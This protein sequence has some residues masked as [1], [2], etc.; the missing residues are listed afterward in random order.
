MTSFA[1]LT[2]NVDGLVPA[3]VQ[4][5]TTR[6]VLMLGYM[7][8]QAWDETH[9]SGDVHFWSRSRNELWRKGGTSGN[10]LIVE[11][12]TVDCDADAV[13]VRATPTGPT[14]HLGTATCWGGPDTTL[15]MA[16]DALAATIADRVASRPDGS[17]SVVLADDTDLAARKV[18]EEAGE[19][20]FAAKDVGAGGDPVRLV[21]EA[22]DVVYHLLALLAAT[23]IDPSTVGAELERR[24]G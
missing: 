17:Y 13:L 14:C 20:A 7:N 10:R 3:I 1:D 22:A 4:D 9:A 6:A 2:T 5:A 11:S 21:E 24:R 18:L 15:G 16:V 8:E 19:A 12:I 23:G